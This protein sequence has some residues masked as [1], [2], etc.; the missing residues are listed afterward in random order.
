MLF[1]NAWQKSSPRPSSDPAMTEDS[2]NKQLQDCRLSTAQMRDILQLAGVW[3]ASYNGMP[4]Y[5][6]IRMHIN[7]SV[8]SFPSVRRAYAF[9]IRHQTNG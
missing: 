8:W 4:G 5:T 3:L 6:H 7:A 2:L 9:F 1:P